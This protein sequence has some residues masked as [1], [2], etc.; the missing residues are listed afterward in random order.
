MATASEA[1]QVGRRFQ[2][3][4]LLTMGALT[5]AEVD[6]VLAAGSEVAVWREG[7]RRHLAE[8]ARAQGRP[9]PGP[10][11]VRQRHGPAR[12]LPTP[13]RCWRWPAPAPPSPSLELAGVW[14]H[15]ATADEPDSA[16][17]DEQLDR[18][19]RGR[20]RRQGRVPR[21]LAHA[22]NSAA[23]FRDRRSHFDMARCGVAVYGLDPFQGDP[24]ER[25]LAPALSLRSYVADVK[26]FPAGASAGYGQ[27]W[28]AP[29]ETWVG[30]VPLGYGDG[31]RRGLSNNAEVLV[32]GRRQPLVGT[33][34]MDN[35]TIDLGPE[36]DVEPGDEAVLIGAQGED[37]ILAEEVAAPARHDQLRGHLR[38]LG[39][40]A[41]PRRMSG[42]RFA[43][44]DDRAPTSPIGCAPA[45]GRSA[46]RALGEGEGIWI[47][48]G[49]VRDAALGREVVDLDLAVAGD[50]RAAGQGDRRASSASTPSS[51]RPS[52]TPGACSS[53]PTAAGRSTS[54]ALRGETIEADL[55]ER[56]FTIGAVAVPLG[57]R[58]AARPLRRPGRPRAPPA[59]RRRRAQLR[60][61]P[62]AAAARG[63]PRRRA[64]GLEVDP[65]DGPRSPAP[66]PAR[67]AEPAGERQLA[68]LR[69]LLG[70][71]DPL[72][73]LALLDE[74]GAD[75]RRPARAGGAARRRTGPQPPPRRPRPHPGGARAHARGRGATS[76]A[77]PASAPPRCAELLAEPLADEM[78]RGTAL[79]FGALF[80]DI[81]KPATRSEQ[82]GF[83]TFLGHDRDGAEIVGG[84]CRPAARQP[85]TS[86]SHLQAPDPA[87]PAARL[88]DPRG[89]AAA[90]PRP[91]VPA[92]DRTGRRRRHPADR[93]RPPL[94][95]R[96][97]AR[98]PARRR[99][100]P[101]STSPAQMIAAALDWR[102]EGPPRAAAARRRA[103][104]P[105]WDIEP[106]PEL[107]ELLA[108]LEAAQYAGEVSDRAEALAY[109]AG[110]AARRL[111]RR[112]IRLRSGTLS[113]AWRKRKRSKWRA[114][115]PRP[116]PTRCSGS[117]WTTATTCSATSPGK[118]RRHYIRILPGDRVKIELSPY[119]LD[120]GRITYRYK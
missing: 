8:R 91:R 53:P 35:L 47:V 115:S 92:G 63:P 104:A 79:R 57:R 39:S 3:I 105:S 76:S 54:T 17:F 116:S 59:A 73:G 100:R 1:E 42:W 12:Q 110:S 81:G 88:H 98:S 11:Q 99:S 114:R 95:P 45:A 119:D 36:T 60:R 94:R 38:D 83:V 97:R 34:S 64:C 86:P 43:R 52:S 77:S 108:E 37:A 55:A 29:G 31:V 74:L 71:P 72:R 67:A 5:A 7:F 20:R 50:P 82:D 66:Q 113:A 89:A 93:R 44:Y 15:F 96:R 103:R 14:T 80:H 21:R 111:G 23:V 41:A 40:G 19:D 46:R 118:M 58:R 69:Q 65:D 33:V 120:R 30:V 24:A 61:R 85:P 62:A 25:G 26:R 75:R 32:G 102:R 18:F 4:P 16:F 84:I 56:D 10:R 27:R 106:G 68:E 109:L 6:V 107:G 51:S 13:T 48:G 78:S 90:A 101:T 70:G 2:H 28:M 22:A 49:A 117:N 112:E 87:P 9:A